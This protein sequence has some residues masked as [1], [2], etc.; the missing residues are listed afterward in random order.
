MLEMNDKCKSD[1]CP[2]P[3]VCEGNN[4]NYKREVEPSQKNRKNGLMT[5]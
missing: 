2:T 5:S 1:Q 3:Q 4:L